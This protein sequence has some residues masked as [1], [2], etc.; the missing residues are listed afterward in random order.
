M[1][2]VV[3]GSLGVALSV[4]VVLSG[5]VHVSLAVALAVVVDLEAVPD[6]PAP[7]KDKRATYAL[8]KSEPELT[9]AESVV[10][11][12]SSDERAQAWEENVGKQDDDAPWFR[13]RVL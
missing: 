13:N 12:I 6:S 11:A 3:L 2:T 8:K 9:A 4:G 7:S 5:H 10:L 1:L